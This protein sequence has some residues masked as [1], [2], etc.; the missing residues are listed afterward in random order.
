MNLML[1]NVSTRRFGRAVRL[2]EGDIAAAPGAGVSKSAVSRRFVALSAE[3]MSQWMAADLSQLDLLAIQIDGMHV[4]S[5]LTLLA[6]VGIDAAGA[7][8]PLGLLEGATENT[9]VVS[10]GQRR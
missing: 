6:A 3:R 8:H 1:I 2:P 10:T 4:T 9:A 5:E 7:K